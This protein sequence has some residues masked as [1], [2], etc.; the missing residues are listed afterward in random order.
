[1]SGKVSSSL[2]VFLCCIYHSGPQSTINIDI[3]INKNEELA[4]TARNISRNTTSTVNKE[5]VLMMGEADTFI[6]LDFK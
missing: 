2:L 6:Y 3:N 1:M 4:D 5:F